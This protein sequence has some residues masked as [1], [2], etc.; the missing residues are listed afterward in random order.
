MINNDLKLLTNNYRKGH[1]V[2]TSLVKQLQTC[3]RFIFS[4]AFITNSGLASIIHELEKSKT[5]NKK[6]LIIT[7]DY[8][9][10]NEP[11]ALKR[12]MAFDNLELRVIEEP[13]FHIK[14]YIFGHKDHNQYIIGSSNLTQNA[15]TSN[16]EWNIQFASYEDQEIARQI[17]LELDYLLEI[18]SELTEVWLDDYTIR[19][20]QKPKEVIVQKPKYLKPNK[21]QFKALH[22]L[23]LQRELKHQ[24]ALVISATGTGKT[25]LSAFDAR[26]MDAKRLLFVV[27]REQIAK[28]AM[29]SFRDVFDEERTYGLYTGNKQEKEADFLFSTIQTLSKEYH[30]TQFEP[31]EF[32]YIIYDEAHHIGAQSYQ[33]IL[34]YFNPKFALAMTATPERNDSNNIYEYMDNNI[35]YEIRL[36]EA[37]EEDMLCPFHYYGISDLIIDG[38]FIS[39]LSSFN[40]LITD[41]RV[42]HIIEK[43]NLY[44]Y[45]GDRVK[46]LVFCS[47]VEEAHALSNR[48][49]ER[50]FSTLAL[51][52]ANTQSERELAIQRLTSDT[53]LDTLD[54]IFTVDIFNEGVDIPQ[55]NQVV[56]LRPTQSAIIFVQQLGRGLRKIP[57]KEFVVVIDFIGNYQNNFFIPIA[58]SGDRTFDKETLYKFVKKANHTIPGAST[59]HFDDVVKEQV[60]KSVKQTNFATKRF[61]KQAYDDLKFKLNTIPKLIE[62][63]RFG[64]VDPRIILQYKP[65]YYQFLVNIDPDFNQDVS[66][67]Q[68]KALTFLSREILYNKRP[69][70]VVILEE[71]LSNQEVSI[72]RLVDKYGFQET[73][74]YHALRVLSLDF[75]KQQDQEKYGNE[76][77]II[78]DNYHIRLGN[79][80]VAWLADE[81]FKEFVFDLV[82]VSATIISEEYPNTSDN[83]FILYKRYSRKDV[84]KLLNWERDDSSTMYGYV[85]KEDATP[86]FVTYNKDDSFTK[87]T[88]Y[89]D[90]IVNEEH[91]IWYTKSNRTFESKDVRR[92]K[93]HDQTNMKIDLFIK[94]DDKEKE[95]YY[96]GEMVP[97]RFVSETIEDDKKQNLPIVKIDMRFKESLHDDMIEYFNEE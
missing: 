90:E 46:G 8:M 52:G 31:D 89:E 29:N 3:N 66:E 74:I 85:A 96:L 33:K 43:M 10:F 21:L 14:G 7:T 15:L 59:I 86:I 87:S 13:D 28:A 83:P 39:D 49:N 92:I 61:L 30:Y 6:G 18:S 94:K 57:N 24:K 76:S 91:F 70:E 44:G 55:I 22:A 19:Y 54:Y 37:L 47:R 2:L 35:A 62:F 56:M 20:N 45:C 93:N 17:N 1:K 65:N 38:E 64:M 40:Q 88:L 9:S 68:N 81:I 82:K 12:L 26:N 48:F 75:F 32:D 36:N 58:L 69:H 25:Y 23:E 51:S 71:L 67:D 72:P 97:E 16:L 50:G 77:L 41:H 4:V 80:F 78:V 53:E 79:R 95:F 84:C 11:S 34:N 5:E 27:H 42:D 60:L 63:Y 73:T